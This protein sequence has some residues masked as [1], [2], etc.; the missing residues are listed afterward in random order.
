MKITT[1][2]Q[3]FIKRAFTHNLREKLLSVLCTAVVMLVA[4]CFKPVNKVY[5]VK[6]NTKIPPDQVLVSEN[7]DHI[8]VKV[9]GNFFELRKVKNEDL[10]INFDFSSEKAGEISRNIGDNELPASFLPLDVESILPQILVFITEEKKAEPAEPVET[11][12]ETSPE[13][14]PAE[15]E[16]EPAETAVP[17]TDE[18][19][20]KTENGEKND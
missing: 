2:K 18:N 15:S 1:Q 5:S 9:S 7:I 20:V 13:Q 14:K 19:A 4:V 12:S 11:S 17:K 6:I 3:G 16:S 8:E 10:V